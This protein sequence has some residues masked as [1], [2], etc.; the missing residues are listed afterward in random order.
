MKRIV[1]TILLALA[2]LAAAR[3]DAAPAQPAPGCAWAL[4]NPAQGVSTG[5]WGW[6]DL[7]RSVPIDADTQFNLASLSKQFTAL[8]VLLLVADG[9][10]DLDQPLGAYLESL[11]G[12][13]GRPS[14]RQVLQH[15]G[16][17]PDYI[18]PLYKAGRGSETATVADTLAVLAAAPTLRFEPGVRFEYSNTGYF[19]LAQLVERVSGQSLAVFSQRYIFGPLGMTQTAIVDRYPAALPR[20]ARG[21]R[22]EKGQT[23][24]VE[25]SWEQTGDGQVHSSATD[26]HRWLVHLDQD[27]VLDSPGGRPLAGVRTALTQGQ[28]VKPKGNYQFGLETGLLAD[29]A[30]WGHAGGWAGY[31]SFMA[32]T[33]QMHRGAA[34][35]CNATHLDVRAMTQ[36]L[37]ISGIG[38]LQAQ[39][40]R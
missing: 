10:V 5:A 30:A 23:Q 18:D 20:L 13:L 11:P 31:H 14:I 6:A 1:T 32:Y 38:Q 36:R 9:R 21:Y 25:S 15:T 19:L 37:L 35:V 28:A 24:V 17:L 33:P 7:E 40:Y 34:V 8:A 27:T 26:L 29:V 12:E 4:L 2:P 16:G 22:V 39:A 3:A